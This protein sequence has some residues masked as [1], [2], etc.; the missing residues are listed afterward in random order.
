MSE[1]FATGNP[2]CDRWQLSRVMDNVASLQREIS[3]F[4]SSLPDDLILSNKNIAGWL[5]RRDRQVYQFLHEWICVLH[6]DLYQF[7]LP[8]IRETGEPGLL[9]ILPAEFKTNSQMQAIAHAITLARFWEAWLEKSEAI[10]HPKPVLIGDYNIIPCVRQCNKVLLAA[11]ACGLH[12][13][14]KNWKSTTAPTWR[15]EEPIT[16]QSL[17]SLIDV[18]LRVL[19]PWAGIIPSVKPEVGF[20]VSV[21]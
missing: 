21:Q 3:Q 17:R 16:L 10:G 8:L 6:M 7:S 9:N 11:L 19:E 2:P 4:I 18:T 14:L 1:K 13:E 12:S 5:L 15:M 20:T